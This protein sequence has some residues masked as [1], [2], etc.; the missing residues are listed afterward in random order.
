MALQSRGLPLNHP[1]ASQAVLLDP[2]RGLLA[3]LR[4]GGVGYVAQ[5]L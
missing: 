5:G 4:A 3:V 2:G 1:T